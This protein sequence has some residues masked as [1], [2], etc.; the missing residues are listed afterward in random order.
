MSDTATLI[1]TNVTYGW[2]GYSLTVGRTYTGLWLFNE[3]GPGAAVTLDEGRGA[4]GPDDF[5]LQLV[6]LD[7]LPISD[8]V[9]RVSCEDAL[10]YAY[11]PAALFWPLVRAVE[12]KPE[13]TVRVSLESGQ[14]TLM[15]QM[16]PI[17]RCNASFHV[18]KRDE[19]TVPKVSFYAPPE[20]PPKIQI[21]GGLGKKIKKHP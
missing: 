10:T 18:G 15:N 6:Q 17:L 13:G 9:I 5:R 20:A 14:T 11:L 1:D 8:G 2:S 7:R 3:G 4:S 12:V 21:A 16:Q 19:V